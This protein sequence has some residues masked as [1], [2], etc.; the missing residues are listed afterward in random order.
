MKKIWK[1]TYLYKNSSIEE[2]IDRPINENELDLFVFKKHGNNN[3]LASLCDCK[4]IGVIEVPAV[5]EE[6]IFVTEWAHRD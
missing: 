3:E 2:Y 6:D 4:E 1:I 5:K